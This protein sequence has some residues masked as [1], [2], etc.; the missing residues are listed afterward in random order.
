MIWPKHETAGSGE[1]L[2]KKGRHKGNRRHRAARKIPCHAPHKSENRLPACLAPGGLVEA[3][4]KRTLSDASASNSILALH[5]EINH[6]LVELRKEYGRESG[7]KEIE[8]GVE[9]EEDVDTDEDALCFAYHGVPRVDPVLRFAVERREGMKLAD[10]VQDEACAAYLKRSRDY[11]AVLAALIPAEWR[12]A[13]RMERDAQAYFAG[14]N[15]TAED[16]F[17]TFSALRKWRSDRSAGASL[18]FGLKRLDAITGGIRGRILAGAAPGVGKTSLALDVSRKAL[19]R[20]QDLGVVYLSLDLPKT[21]LFYYMLAQEAEVWHRLI[22]SD[23]LDDDQRQRCSEAGARLAA[24]M[25]RL[26]IVDD[27]PPILASETIRNRLAHVCAEFQEEAHVSRLFVV[28]D[29]I[30]RLAV[31]SGLNGD[32]EKDEYRLNLLRAFSE[33]TTDYSNPEG[34]PILAISEVRKENLDEKLGMADLKGSSRHGYDADAIL[35]L[36]RGKH[37]AQRDSEISP[38]TLHVAKARDGEAGSEA[39]LLFH[40]KTC[41]FVESKPTPRSGKEKG[42]PERHPVNPFAGKP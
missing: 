2:Q 10:A 7:Y 21:K 31:P 9:I 13:A 20:E 6:S 12:E 23:E 15:L 34:Y 22:A 40:W 30:Q 11:D 19:H 37:P 26:R 3:I 41:R 38:V 32:L 36:W 39:N 42:H 28:V 35:L 1:Q 5:Q 14:T 18:S 27:L 8:P 4:L 29:P 17:E 24:I 16:D 33:K 25:T